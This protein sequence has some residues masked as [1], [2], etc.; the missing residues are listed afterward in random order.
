[1]NTNPLSGTGKVFKF[2]LKQTISAKGWLVSTVLIAA[3]LLIGIPLIL[4]AASSAANDEEEPDPNKATLKTVYVVDETEGTVDY[5]I[6]KEGQEGDYAALTYTA[7][8]TTDAA[9]AEADKKESTV[10]L[11][12]TK[13]DNR[14]LVTVILPDESSLSRSDASAF[15]GF[16]EGQFPNILMAKAELTQEGVML[17]K[18]PVSSE[19]MSLSKDSG[20]DSEEE[21]ISEKLLGFFVPFM[22]IML[23]YMMVLLYGQSVA[24]SVMLE[25][26]S[27][28]IESILTAVNPVALMTG[29]LLAGAF[30]AILQLMIWLGCLLGG[31]FGGA[32]F[33][34]RMVPD[35]TNST[36]GTVNMIME[37]D[38]NISFVGLALGL[39]V[40]ALGFVLYLSLSCL[41]GSLA[42]KQEDLNKTNVVFVLVLVGSFFI[43][44][45]S[46][47][48][49][50]GEQS[51]GSFSI[52]SD[53][54]WMRIFPFTAILVA[55]SD[56][57]MGK[58]S[59]GM[60]A[61]CFAALIASVALFVVIAARVYKLMV[62]YRGNPP[63]PK[64][65]LAML[66]DAKNEKK[67]S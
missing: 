8:D 18:M 40:I 10:I 66:K 48:A 52:I 62:F 22:T 11:H 53:A 59:G 12:I 15:A 28:L 29:K 31:I 17:L 58:L 25:K 24:N 1:M 65:L 55:P 60:I 63:T 47:I 44:V 14:Y 2:S 43:C 21:S 38:M 20:E 45:G 3:L 67:A 6:L 36:V 32:V 41:S 16:V 42:S 39:L 54:G 9:I 51:D 27:K 56:M 4:W 23:L 26:N 49:N 13:P 35:T 61:G 33:A 57:L 30:A 64:A 37:S 19:T 7:F 46:G 50:M 5:S 34:M